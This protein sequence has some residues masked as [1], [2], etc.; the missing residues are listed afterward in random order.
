MLM[1]TQ[2]SK[3]GAAAGDSR[4]GIPCTHPNISVQT[5]SVRGT[6]PSLPVGQASGALGKCGSTHPYFPRAMA[7]CSPFVCLFHLDLKFCSEH[8]FGTQLF[9]RLWIPHFP[10][11]LDGSPQPWPHRP[12]KGHVLTP[13]TP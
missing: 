4:S 11:H 7:H 13:Q 8:T 9:F 10:V 1:P 2:M 5:G 3:S 12:L 6:A